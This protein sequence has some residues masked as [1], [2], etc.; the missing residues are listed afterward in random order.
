MLKPTTVL[1]GVRD[2]VVV[3]CLVVVGITNITAQ[4]LSSD[5]GPV[6]AQ[7]PAVDPLTEMGEMVVRP[8][9]PT[10]ELSP[11][12]LLVRAVL[13]AVVTPGTEMVEGGALVALVSPAERI[14]GIGPVCFTV[15]ALLQQVTSLAALLAPPAFSWYRGTGTT[16]GL[17][18]A[19]RSCKY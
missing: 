9:P 13:L 19:G 16:L 1:A 5:S 12:A 6:F 8:T 7:L 11:P 15:R 17:L 14:P 2:L 4:F 18:C 10:L 3:L